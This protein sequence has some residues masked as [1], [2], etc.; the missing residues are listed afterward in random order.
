MKTFNHVDDIWEALETCTTV[1]QIYDILDNI[2]QKFGTWWADVVGENE[3]EV[4]NQWWDKYQEDMVVESQIFEVKLELKKEDEVAEMAKANELFKEDEEEIEIETAE[5]DPKAEALQLLDEIRNI[6]GGYA[7]SAS[8]DNSP[9]QEDLE[10]LE[11]KLS[12]LNRK[13]EAI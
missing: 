5:K 2:P 1:D 7:D 11:A 8:V 4:T 6:V 3:I 12:E 13:L 9:T 10:V